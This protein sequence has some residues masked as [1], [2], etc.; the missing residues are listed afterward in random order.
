M[1]RR[2][3]F[4]IVLAASLTCVLAAASAHASGARCPET[5]TIRIGALVD[6]T[7]ASTSP[8]YRKAVELAASQMNEALRRDHSCLT[9][10]VVFGDTKSTP[11]LAQSEAI[12]LINQHG[13]VALVSDSSGDTVAVNRL[14][15]DPASPALQ[16][17]PVTCFQCSSG[18]INDP[19]V[20]ELDPLTQASERDLDNWLFRVFYN[21][22]YEAAALVQVAL[23]RTGPGSDGHLKI[24]I[25]ADAGHRSLAT[26]IVS[27]LPSYYTDPASTE[28]IFL[29]SL[30][31]IGADWARVVDGY[32]EGTAET[33][34]PPDVVIMAMLP[35]S[36][37][38][39]ILSYRAAGYT[40][41]ILSNNSFR[42]DYI[43]AYVGA[44][45][46]GLEGSSV[47]LVDDSRSGEAFVNAFQAFTGQRPELTSSGAYDATV[48]LMLAALAAHGESD[49]I[50]PA[51]VRTGLTRINAPRALKVRPRVVDFKVAALL[52]KLGLPIN[53]EG[54]YDKLDWDEVGD[55]FPP[56]VHWKVEDQQFVE[57]E[58]FHC[59]V[60]NPLCPVVP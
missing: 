12:R 39:G 55:I 4:D 44:V 49:E 22:K 37:A 24:G 10:E 19:T 38:E 26:S 23:G 15:Y 42:R 9:F 32:N 43:L 21:A 30:A 59:D 18:F 20:V 5:S 48:S 3:R 35:G 25:L 36:A 33:D 11:A 17:V 41:P 45:A 51:G 47:A 46:N 54:A 6:Q 28:I 40:Y 52:L 27:T 16:K 58:S 13:V 31:N 50:T 57:Y 60:A 56:L 1:S 2:V 14:N 34:G 53:Y 8:L 29:S 7:G